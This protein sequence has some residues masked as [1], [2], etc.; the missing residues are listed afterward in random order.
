MAQFWGAVVQRE[1]LT[2]LP[3]SAHVLIFYKEKIFVQVKE[4]LV[5][6]LC[7]VLGLSLKNLLS[8]W[9]QCDARRPQSAD[10]PVYGSYNFQFSVTSSSTEHVG[11]LYSLIPPLHIREAYIANESSLTIVVIKP[12]YPLVTQ[13]ST[14]SK[15]TNL[16]PRQMSATST[17]RIV[18]K[19]KSLEAI[20]PAVGEEI[21]ASPSVVNVSSDLQLITLHSTRQ[22]ARR[23]PLL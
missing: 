22:E 10:R 11:P 20:V 12:D 3:A 7:S 8:T 23:L 2:S 15:T 6:A 17:Y 4:S 14:H 5:S 16:D 13:N 9:I 19:S 1:D 21:T 18:T